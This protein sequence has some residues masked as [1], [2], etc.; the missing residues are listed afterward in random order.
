MLEAVKQGE[1]TLT[2]E[3]KA[4]REIVLEAVKQCGTILTPEHK[5][6]RE[7]VLEAVKQCETFSSHEHKADREIVLEVGK[8]GT[9]KF[10]CVAPVFTPK[11]CR[12][13]VVRRAYRREKLSRIRLSEG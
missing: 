8:Q 4:G 1:N 5:A 11:G 9:F 2:P 10:C 3:H 12:T 7:I 6:R 13:P